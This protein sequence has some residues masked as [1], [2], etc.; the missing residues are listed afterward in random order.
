[1]TPDGARVGVVIP[2]YRVR[3]HIAHV[4][5]R[6]GP[7]V[8]AIYV[9]DDRCPEQSGRHV[10][11]HV[12]DPRVRVIEHAENQGVGGAM[13]TGYRVA[14]AEGMDVVVKIDGDGQMD[15]AHLPLLLGP[16]SRGHADYAKGNRFHA[17]HLLK[18][19]PW[20][21]LLGNSALSFINKAVSGYWHVMDPTNGYTAI[22]RCALQALPLDRL[23]RRYF[24]ESDMLFRLALAR[25][26]VR[27]VPLP[28]TYGHETSSLQVRRILL[29]FPPKF[30]SRFMKRMAYMYFV[31]DFNLGSIW[32]VTSAACFGF[33]AVFGGYHWWKSSHLGQPAT[34]GTVMVAAMPVILGFQ[35]LIGALGIDVANVPSRP[36][37]ETLPCADGA[38]PIEASR[39]GG[40]R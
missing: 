7:L 20:V 5:A 33:S 23:D 17:P 21:R 4:I 30:L 26:V 40:L 31:R 3:A 12:L 1:V 14:L 18:S 22:H 34:A 10:R 8:D 27:D 25:A 35:A 28:A 24:F 9:V 39:A 38:V 15:P 11:D 2:A 16:I 19:M 29:E 13:V 37:S 32:W 36:L 6:I